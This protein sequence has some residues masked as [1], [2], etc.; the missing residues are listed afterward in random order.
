[1]FSTCKNENAK[2]Q[3]N[4]LT[5]LTQRLSNEIESETFDSVATFVAF[6]YKKQNKIN[7]ENM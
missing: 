3:V 5:Q 4:V 6:S 1:M 7:K 2:M